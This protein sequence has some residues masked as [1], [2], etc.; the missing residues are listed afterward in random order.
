MSLF[1]WLILPTSYTV[2]FT[3]SLYL[4]LQRIEKKWTLPIQDWKRA[5]NHFVILFGNRVTL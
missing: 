2:L 1:F 3:P 5:L 4:G